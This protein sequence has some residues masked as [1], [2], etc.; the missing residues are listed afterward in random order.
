LLLGVTLTIFCSFGGD[1][2]K[3]K[4]WENIVKWYVDFTLGSIINN[5]INHIFISKLSNN[6][7]ISVSTNHLIYIYIYMRYD[8]FMALVQ[9]QQLFLKKKKNLLLNM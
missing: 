7:H 4:V 2:S 8:T 3:L 5:A 1:I 9:V 6:A